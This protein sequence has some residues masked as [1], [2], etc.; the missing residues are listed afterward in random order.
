MRYSFTNTSYKREQVGPATKILK[1]DIWNLE[2]INS[3][4]GRLYEIAKKDVYNEL[5]PPTLYEVPIEDLKRI[6]EVKGYSAI[7]VYPDL[8]QAI[9]RS[10][11]YQLS[12][13]DCE[14]A[15]GYNCWTG[16]FIPNESV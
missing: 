12:V 7:T 1:T 16:I 3:K 4:K 15:E 9:L 8:N 5:T 10:F 2:S 13:D 6:V 11:D 14:Q